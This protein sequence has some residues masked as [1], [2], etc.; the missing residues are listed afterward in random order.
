MATK[1]RCVKQRFRIRLCQT[2]NGMLKELILIAALSIGMFACKKEN[3]HQIRIKVIN[4]TQEVIGDAVLGELRIGS[5]APGQAS[6]FYS[7]KDLFA[8]PLLRFYNRNNTVV[9]STFVCGSPL[10]PYL[11]KGEYA[12]QVRKDSTAPDGYAYR[13]TKL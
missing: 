2:K 4:D 6:T 12:Y 11:E 10:P 7:F 1:T 13:F 8:P 5:L 3:E 9:L